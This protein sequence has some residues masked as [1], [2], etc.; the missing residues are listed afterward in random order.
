MHRLRKAAV[1]LAA[2][3]TVGLVTAGTAHADGHG[4]HIMQSSNC[5]DHDL[6]LDLLG[7]VGILN[8]LLGNAL[9][10]E[11]DPGAQQTHVGSTMGCS[12]KAG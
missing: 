4:G 2:V 8:G 9:N 3:S 6:N 7:E 1:L 11:G 12:N 5:K 10:G